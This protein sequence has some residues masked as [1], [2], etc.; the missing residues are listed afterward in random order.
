MGNR[1]RRSFWPAALLMAVMAV[2][3]GCAGSDMRPDP[4]NAVYSHDTS[5]SEDPKETL[6]VTDFSW[7]YQPRMKQIR[8]SGKVRNDGTEPRESQLIVA[9]AIDQ[10]NRPLGTGNSYLVPTY[11]PAGS[12]ATFELN[13]RGGEYLQA[14]RLVY[15]FETLY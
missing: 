4:A 3:G 15:H 11:V 2:L 6:R 14:L 12:E 10:N 13:I 1:W 9:L 5:V 7:R 8:I